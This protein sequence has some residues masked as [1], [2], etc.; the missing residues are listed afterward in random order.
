M[1]YALKLIL[2]F[3]LDIIGKPCVDLMFSSSLKQHITFPTLL[4]GNS[5]NLFDII[6]SNSSTTVQ[7]VVFDPAISDNGITIAF[8]P[9]CIKG[10][11]T[12]EMFRDHSGKCQETPEIFRTNNVFLYETIKVHSN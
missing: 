11:L 8:F 3:K 7:S 4:T 9:S 6:R 2:V 10:K 1:F 12:P 5:V